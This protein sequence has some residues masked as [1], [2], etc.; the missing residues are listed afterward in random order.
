LATF[1]GALLELLVVGSLLDE[2]EDRNRKLG[3]R[4]RVGLRV[5]RLLA[6]QRTQKKPRSARDELDSTE[7]VEKS[8]EV[9]GEKR[10]PGLTIFERWERFRDEE[11]AAAAGKVKS[12]GFLG[13]G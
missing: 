11:K 4:Q 7:M 6:L 1:V 5:H 3:V 8:G 9:S 13:A 2:F 10:G 12:L